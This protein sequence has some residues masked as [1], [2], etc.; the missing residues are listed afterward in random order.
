[1]KSGLT[2]AEFDMVALFCNDT[3]KI[4]SVTTENKFF[5]PDQAIM[6]NKDQERQQGLEIYRVST[7]DQS[8]LTGHRRNMLFPDEGSKNCSKTYHN[9]RISLCIP[10]EN[11]V[12]HAQAILTNRYQRQN[13]GLDISR[14]SKYYCSN[15][16]GHHRNML[17]FYEGRNKVSNPGLDTDSKPNLDTSKCVLL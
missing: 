9:K 6:I 8:N 12:C 14:V 7:S 5:R 4:I 13:V 2:T 10:V 15:I 17:L 16:I 3:R 11:F 1:M